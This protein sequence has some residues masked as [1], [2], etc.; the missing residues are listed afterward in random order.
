METDFNRAGAESR[1]RVPLTGYILSG[2]QSR[3]FGNDK[4]RALIDNQPLL[5][6]IAERMQHSC[7]HVFTV[8]DKPEK[9]NDLG[10][11]TLVDELPDCG[12]L[13]GLLTAL[14]HAKQNETDWILLA[15]CDLTELKT[16]WINLL[17]QSITPAAD[18]I[19]FQGEFRKDGK[20]RL[21]EPF[22]GLYHTRLTAALETA[23]AEG[24]RS[25][26]KLLT[27]H[28]GLVTSIEK[29]ADWPSVAQINTTNE[30][31]NYLDQS[32]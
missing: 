24:T 22:P 29:P 9:Y 2:G 11:V 23:I 25:F 26:Q 31:R 32:P 3:R 15:S 13:A 30:L 18:V 21:L 27:T 17:Q 8:A 7:N 6:R 20:T 14:H 28:K 5:I 12:P 10:L 16:S 19:A 1:D 4:A